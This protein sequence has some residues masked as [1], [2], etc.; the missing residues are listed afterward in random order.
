MSDTQR[1]MPTKRAILI[2]LRRM[3]K[4]K[5]GI[6]PRHWPELADHAARMEGYGCVTYDNLDAWIYE[7]EVNWREAIEG[8]A[9]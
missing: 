5:L 8:K 3:V 1:P 7:M 6:D 4:E 2:R 9:L